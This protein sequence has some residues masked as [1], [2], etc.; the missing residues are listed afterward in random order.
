MP[1]GGLARHKHL[2]G[3]WV[4]ILNPY[5][6]LG[7]STGS[8]HLVM[9]LPCCVH[10]TRGMNLSL[11]AQLVPGHAYQSLGANGGTLKRREGLKV[12]ISC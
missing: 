7:L 9:D 3:C 1:Q 6:C 8:Y 5:H 10:H 4:S 11:T 12:Y 2:F